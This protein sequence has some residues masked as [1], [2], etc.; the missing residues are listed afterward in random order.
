[1]IYKRGNGLQQKEDD[2]YPEL[3]LRLLNAILLILPGRRGHWFF[4]IG[5]GGVESGL[6]EGILLLHK[7]DR[8]KFIVPSHLAFDYWETR[9]RYLR[10][11]PLFMMSSL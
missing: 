7:G 6:E 1:M 8:V 3:F 9:I 4:E 11:L 10:G 5:H 2:C